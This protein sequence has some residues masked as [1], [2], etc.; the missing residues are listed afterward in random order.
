[1]PLEDNVEYVR[2]ILLAHEEYSDPAHVEGR[3]KHL[4]KYLE[5]TEIKEPQT[6]NVED[7]IVLLDDY[8]QFD[9]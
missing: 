8:E 7:L 3:A 4:A 9:G 2:R 5:R 1:M 6:F